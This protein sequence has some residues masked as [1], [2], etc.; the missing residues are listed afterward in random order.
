M[1]KILPFLCL[2]LLAGCMDPVTTLAVG[3]ATVATYSVTGKS[4]FDY[5]LSRARQQDC[6]IRNPKRHDGLYCVNEDEQTALAP[7]PEVY[8]YATLGMPDCSRQ[9]DP[10]NNGEQPI[11]GPVATDRALRDPLPVAGANQPIT[12][13]PALPEARTVREAPRPR[14]ARDPVSEG[15]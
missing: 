12:L 8:C 7:E 1:G 4:P 5:G 9:L 11:V 3:G 2:A 15:S 10:H 13:A 14:E 6:D